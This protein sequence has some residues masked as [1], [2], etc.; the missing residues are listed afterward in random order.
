[1]GDTTQAAHVIGKLRLSATTAK[2]PI[3]G[4]SNL[5]APVA[6]ALAVP[7]DQRNDAQK[8]EIAKYYRTIDGDL[9]RMTAE[10]GVRGPVGDPRLMGAQDLVWAMLNSPAFLFNR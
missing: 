8:A 2:K 7:A 3:G 4:K 10:L 9:V 1:M 5:P 6:A